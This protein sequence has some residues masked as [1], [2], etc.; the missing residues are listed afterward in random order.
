[1]PFK[2]KKGAAA[3]GIDDGWFEPKSRTWVPI[4]G[5]VMKGNNYIDGFMQTLVGVDAANITEAIIEMIQASPHYRQLQVIFTHGIT[6]AGFGVL[7]TSR[8]HD[9]IQLPVITI[10]DH[11]PNLE[12]IK[13]SLFSHFKDADE[14]WSLMS[15]Q[16]ELHQLEN[17]FWFQVV[18]MLP[19]DA[20]RVIR[21][22]Q[23]KSVFPE[24]LRIA[25]L[26]GRIF[27]DW[28]VCPKPKE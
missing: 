25:H 9:E 8:L 2:L 7:D 16:N 18:G 1:M 10:L 23:V 21:S 5:C 3:V 13:K 22:Y 28:L 19:K 12:K 4:I 20:I 26:T 17:S 14:R 6:F 27:R 15:S 24:P 11:L